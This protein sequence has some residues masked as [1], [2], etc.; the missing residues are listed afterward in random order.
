M[1]KAGGDSDQHKRQHEERQVS[2]LRHALIWQYILFAIL[3]QKPVKR[4]EAP[5]IMSHILDDLLLG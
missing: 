4:A 5:Q 3:H 1:A 2:G